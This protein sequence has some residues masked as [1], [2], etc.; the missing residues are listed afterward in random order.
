MTFAL[1]LLYLLVAFL[2]TETLFGP[3]RYYHIEE[4]LLITTFCASLPALQ[5]TFVQKTVQSLALV[6]LSIA[7]FLS[8]AIGFSYPRY[9]FKEIMDF[10]PNAFA[11]FLVVL[12]CRTKFRLKILIL[13]LFGVCLFVTVHGIVELR[14]WDGIMPEHQ[15]EETADFREVNPEA[16][17]EKD[18][19]EVITYLMPQWNQEGNLIWRLKGQNFLDDPN[20]FGQLLVC[21]LPLIFIFW[22]PKQLALNLAVVGSMAGLISY[23]IYLTHSRG[24]LL[25]ALAVVIVA[26]RRKIGS[27]LSVILGGGL[28]VGAMAM[29]ATGGREISAG[30]GSDR[31]ALWGDGLQMLK[32]HPVFGVGYGEMA[33]LLGKT[34]HNTVIV[35]AAELGFFGLFFWSLFL[36]PTMRDAIAV[37]APG[38]LNDAIPV[39]VDESPYAYATPKM[40]ALDK[41]EINQMGRLVLFSLIGFLV[42]AMFLSRAFVM[43]FFLLGG[44]AEVIFQMALD[45]GMIAP[46][47]PF[48]RVLAYSGV[49]TVLLVPGMYVIVRVLNLM[50]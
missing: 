40:E 3:L 9:A 29:G 42:A 26:F 4:L 15:D 17:Q 50:H 10:L 43:T 45:R 38:G 25:A 31:T 14:A 13:L 36:F 5:K 12:H 8:I 21:V 23:A 47:L 32:T 44:M 22:R 30:A 11:Y 39:P 19:P 33:D 2:G 7:V 24:A 41:E 1:A 28:F 37:A 20:D 27:V 49:L 16:V 34:A 18:G 6:G 35:C 46:R 48:G